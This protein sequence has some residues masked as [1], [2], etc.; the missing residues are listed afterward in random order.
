MA[1]DTNNFHKHYLLALI[2]SKGNSKQI[3]ALLKSAPPSVLK[4]ICNASLIATKA[5][6]KFDRKLQIYF[7]SNEKYFKLLN[8]KSI[9][10]SNKRKTL[11]SRSGTNFLI[12]LLESIISIVGDHLFQ[13]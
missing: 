5:E 11:S 2:S 8:D 4:I 10:L 6:I 1:K 12:T 7:R 3:K 9:S 13:K